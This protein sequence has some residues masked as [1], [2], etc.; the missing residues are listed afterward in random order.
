MTHNLLEAHDISKVFGSGHTAVR[1]VDGVTLH[2]VRGELVL[3]MGPSGSGKTTLL[4]MLG[5]LLRPTE[6]TIA[7]DDVDITALTESAL[8][9]VRARKI[10]FIFQSDRKSTRLN[11]SHS[12][13]S[14]MPSS[15]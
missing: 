8:P 5:G 1:A 3:V 2:L 12:Q 13:Q 15:A 14:R 11:S 4:S 6:G 9:D 7:I 10:G